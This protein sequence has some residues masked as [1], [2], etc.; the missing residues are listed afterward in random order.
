[1][2]WNCGVGEYVT[3]ES[4]DEDKAPRCGLCGEYERDNPAKKP[5]ARKAAATNKRS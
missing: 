5:A 3:Y 1:M 2:C 4:S